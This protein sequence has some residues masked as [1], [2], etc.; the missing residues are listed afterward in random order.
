MP[1]AFPSTLLLLVLLF[2]VSPVYAVKVVCSYD[3]HQRLLSAEYANGVKFVY[4]YDTLG[5]RLTETI[6]GQSSSTYDDG[7]DGST[8]GW[9]IYDND[10]AGAGIASVT[11]DQ[12]P[13]R[14]IQ[15]SGSGTGNGYRLRDANGGYWNDTTFKVV[16][17]SNRYDQDFVVYIA[18]QTRNGFRYISYTPVEKSGLGGDTYIH[19]GLGVSAKDGSWHTFTRDLAY[20]LKLAQPDNELT[21]VLGF[22]IRGSGKVDDIKTLSTLPATLDT[23][24]DGLTDSDEIT[25]YGTSPYSADTDMDGLNDGEEVAFWGDQWQADSDGDGLINVLDRDADGD[26]FADG[27]ELVQNTDPAEASVHPIAIVYEDA[28]DGNIL[29]WDIYDN[30][31]SGATVANVFDEIRASR[32]IELTGS[33]TTN[34]YRLRQDGGQYWE[35]D[36]FKVLRWS[37]RS[38]EPYVIYIAV[39]T[40]DGFRYLQYTPE[41]VDRLGSDTYIHHGLGAHT[42]DGNWRTLVRDLAYDLKEAQPDNEVVSVLGF[43][44]RGSGRVDDIATLATIPTE[45][46]SDGD[47]LSDIAEMTIYHTHP[48]RADTDGDGLADGEELS[49]W[50]DVWS[51]DTDGDG[52]NNLLDKDADNDGF[53]DGVEVHQGTDP[54]DGASFPVALVYEDAEDGN[55]LGWDIYDSDPAG[56]TITNVDDQERGTK[57]IKLSGAGTANGYR[58]R[59]DDLSYWNDVKFKTIEWSMKYGESF[60]VYIAVQTKNGFRYIYYTPVTVSNLGAETYVQHGLGSIH[61]GSWH[62]V[63]RNLET[64]LKAAQP[65]NELQTV[66]GFLI[67]GSGRVDDVRTRELPAASLSPQ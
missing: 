43:L 51:A 29:G 19:H 9:D 24:N 27:L 7:E 47:T 34:G 14:V 20:D 15:F 39:Q 8:L 32:V 28:E 37:M 30:D 1:R 56:A 64:D 45:Q 4:T 18:V 38:A 31:P 59:S 55:I 63:S 33:G 3:A 13:G 10:P 65:D 25:I 26:G 5:N 21:A 35:D 52:V 53:G 40:R 11:D 12:R 36:T 62:T 6:A 48:Y 61:D 67:R 41:E 58:L 17:W 66:L 46:D 57:V 54:V 22:L 16:E 60:V 50:G 42:R 23:D 44:V 49:F 2:S